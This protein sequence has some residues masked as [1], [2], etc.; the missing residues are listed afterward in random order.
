MANS[1]HQGENTMKG[2]PNE[3]R[4]PGLADVPEQVI[5][6]ALVRRIGLEEFNR[7]L[8]AAERE[9]GLR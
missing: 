9:A 4:Y 2:S 8:E 3:C 7:R 5:I 1:R 6:D